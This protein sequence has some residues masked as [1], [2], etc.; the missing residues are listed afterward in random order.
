MIRINNIKLPVSFT[1]RDVDQAVK[2][3]LKIKNVPSYRFSKL[4]LDDRKRNQVK[5]IA[6]IDVDLPDEDGIVKRLHDNNIMSTKPVR[7]VFPDPG[8]APMRHRPVVIGTGPAGLF[9]A[10]YLAR[11][12]YRPLVFERGMDV[13]R[14]KDAIEAY[15]EGRATLL[16]NCNVQFGDIFRW[17]AQHCNKGW[18]RPPH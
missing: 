11:A 18:I 7:Y 2:K 17:K 3:A 8:D 6:S 1:D 16:P 5:Y 15:W 9:A 4:S 13:D 10:L 14:R 12:G